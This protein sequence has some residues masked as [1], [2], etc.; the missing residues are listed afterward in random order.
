MCICISVCVCMCAVCWRGAGPV[1]NCS[2]KSKILHVCVALTQTQTHTNVNIDM[3]IYLGWLYCSRKRVSWYAPVCQMYF[4]SAV[5][6]TS[7]VSFSIDNIYI[8]IRL[9]YVYT[10]TYIQTRTH[11]HTI[12]DW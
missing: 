10:R 2:G 9:V 1:R 8:C 3:Y 11:A 7:K 6:Q 4:Q 5:L 12:N